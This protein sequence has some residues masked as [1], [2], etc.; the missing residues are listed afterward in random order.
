MFDFCIENHEVLGSLTQNCLQL[1]RDKKIVSTFSVFLVK[2]YAFIT[3]QKSS[4]VECFK[5]GQHRFV[6]A[7]LFPDISIKSTKLHFQSLGKNFSN[8]FA[9]F[10]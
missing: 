3:T 7:H 5:F 4:C 2:K 10:P 1:D 6:F 8:A 9:L